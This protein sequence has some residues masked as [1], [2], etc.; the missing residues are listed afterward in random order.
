MQSTFKKIRK[1]LIIKLFEKSQ[2]F[3]VKYFKK[4]KIAWNITKQE[5]LT[6]SKD[7]LGYQYIQFI[8]KN[9]FEILPKLERH[10]A[11]HI[12]TG[13]KSK[14]QDEIALQYLCFGNGKC[15]I[16][17]F[18]VIILGTILLPDYF[19]YYCQSYRIGK[20]ANPFYNLD[21]EK[22]LVTNLEE[23]QTVIFSKKLQI[24]IN[25]KRI[26]EHQ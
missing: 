19:T 11:Y 21:Y 4:D 14:V 2:N 12:I 18:G 5:L 24:L 10:D 7:T 22:L 13:Y 6:Y 15:S 23:I 26:I 20:Q 25:N 8:I 1:H 17:L 16:Y 9:N 3:Y